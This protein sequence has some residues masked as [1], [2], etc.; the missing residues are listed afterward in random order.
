[1]AGSVNLAVATY[2]NNTARNPLLC[3]SD[4]ITGYNYMIGAP[5]TNS[6]TT[7]PATIATSVN[8]TPQ[9]RFSA[10]VTPV[11]IVA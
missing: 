5:V 4:V 9:S 10:P 1:M 8:R 3:N 7:L 11:L 6:G 2:P